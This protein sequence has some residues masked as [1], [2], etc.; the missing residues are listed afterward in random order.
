MRHTRYG[1]GYALS[2]EVKTAQPGV[3]EPTTAVTQDNEPEPTL[4]PA[5]QYVLKKRQRRQARDKVQVKSNTACFA[6]GTPI[7]V[8]ILGKASWKPIYL[9]EKGDIVVQTLPSGKIEDLTGAL[10]TPIETVCTFDCPTGRIDIVRIGDSI[11]TVHHHIQTTD[12]WMTARQAADMGDGNFLTNCALPRVYN[13]C[14]EG[15]GNILINTTATRQSVLTLTMAATMGCRFDPA[16]DPQHTDSF[17]YPDDIRIR[18]GQIKGMQRGRKH[19]FAH[20]VQTLPNGEIHIKSIRIDPPTS[21]KI[22]PG[23][24]LLPSWHHVTIPQQSILAP[25]RPAHLE[26]GTASAMGKK[27]NRRKPDKGPPGH[28]NTPH[29]VIKTFHRPLE[30]SLCDQHEAKKDWPTTSGTTV[31]QSLP[32]GNIE[33]LWGATVTTIETLC[34]FERPTGGIDLVQ[35]E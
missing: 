21:E 27:E 29:L 9:L 25:R 11:I 23:T 30:E 10:R 7:L 33:D 35:M 8:E 22:R 14:L 32:S 31:V 5:E 15:G 12:G 20:E 26:S 6:L 18:L 19:Y 28:P 2:D 16:V 1:H 24:T 4:T 34:Q 13:L 17:T 3:L